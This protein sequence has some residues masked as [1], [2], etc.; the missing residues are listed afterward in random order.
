MIKLACL[1]WTYKDNSLERALEGIARAGFRY[2]A[3]GLPHEGKMIPDE[4][5]ASAIEPLQVMFARYGLQ[6]IT[7]SANAQFK[8]GQPLERA[9]RY[10]RIAKSFGVREMLTTGT[11]SYRKFPDQPYTDQ[12]MEPINQ[13]FAEHYRQIA[14][15]AAKL[16]MYI[17]IKPHTGNT[18]TAETIMKTLAHLGKAN[19]GGSY[20]PGNVEYYEG[21]NAAKDFPQM[22]SRTNSILIKDHRGPRAHKDFPLPGTGDV[23]FPAIFAALKQADFQGHILV[24][25]VSTAPVEP[26]LN[27]EYVAQTRSNLERMLTEAGFQVE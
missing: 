3:F 12:E 11:C 23:D 22:V 24:E 4:S 16:G 19:I 9:Y 1:T 20:D 2:F 10:L 14:D 18:A 13:A 8:P 27:D 21:V 7:M 17:S 26:D 5:E 6:P 15:E 25:R